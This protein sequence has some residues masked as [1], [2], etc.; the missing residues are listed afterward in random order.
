MSVQL[1]NWLGEGGR[2]Q[3]KRVILGKMFPIINVL[4]L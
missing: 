1:S 2:V 3:N 4:M